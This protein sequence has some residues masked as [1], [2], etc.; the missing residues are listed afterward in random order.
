VKTLEETRAN[1]TNQTS[2]NHSTAKNITEASGNKDKII[3]S[4]SVDAEFQNNKPSTTGTP[5]EFV[6][7]LEAEENVWGFFDE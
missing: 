2:E 5:L 7:D 3:P 4:T 6:R 1:Y